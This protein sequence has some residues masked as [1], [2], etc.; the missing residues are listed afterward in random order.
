MALKKADND[1]GGGGRW[2]GWWLFVNAHGT[3]RF[4]NE[5]APAPTVS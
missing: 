4:W 1:F 5:T 3:K 2:V